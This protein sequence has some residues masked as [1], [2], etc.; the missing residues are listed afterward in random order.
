[1]AARAL[2][3][4]ACN[5]A[6]KQRRIDVLKH[7]LK[8]FRDPTY[9]TL[10]EDRK[11]HHTYDVFRNRDLRKH[12]TFAAVQTRTEFSGGYALLHSI[13]AFPTDGIRHHEAWR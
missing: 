5:D 1:M 7:W 2:T 6:L 8:R 9:L 3:R 12:D 10:Y 11:H 4:T 13:G